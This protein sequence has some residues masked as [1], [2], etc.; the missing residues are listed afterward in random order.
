MKNSNPPAYKSMNA[1]CYEDKERS[2]V[3][4]MN[5]LHY[6]THPHRVPG[7]DLEK[8]LLSLLLII[9]E[10]DMLILFC[11]KSCQAVGEVGSE[12]ES[13]CMVVA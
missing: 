11:C 2:F 1:L 8:R 12:K 9:E 5:D 3:V 10:V 6:E 4:F 13:V 7:E